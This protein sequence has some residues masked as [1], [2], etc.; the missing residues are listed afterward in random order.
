MKERP[1]IAHQ[2]LR[3]VVVA[4]AYSPRKSLLVPVKLLLMSSCYIAMSCIHKKE[5]MSTQILIMWTCFFKLASN[6]E[7]EPSIESTGEVYHRSTYPCIL[8]RHDVRN[9]VVIMFSCPAG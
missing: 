7:G 2:N 3:N 6:M 8:I 9:I 4:I 1:Y 5:M